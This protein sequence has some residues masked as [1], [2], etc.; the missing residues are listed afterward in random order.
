[1]RRSLL[2]LPLLLAVAC[3]GPDPEEPLP[4]GIYE[5]LAVAPYRAGLPHR[6]PDDRALVHDRKYVAAEPAPPP[7]YLLL[8][9]KGH[10]P[11]DL[12]AAPRTDD[13]SGRP[14][15]LL[16]L[17]EEA[18]EALTELT[19]RARRAAV[20]IGGDVVTMHSIRAPIRDGH[21]Q[22]TCCAQGAL[23][24]LLAALGD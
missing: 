22:I 3:G 18:A 19:T 16:D 2:L 20:V 23:E 9:V 13:D 5:V 15:L 1:V 6:G 14:R 10:V 4:D 24:R 11:L 12:A 21:L 17:D 7:E 8:R